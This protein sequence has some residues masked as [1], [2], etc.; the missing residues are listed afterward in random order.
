MPG[1]EVLRQS[2]E[3]GG[4]Q[5]EEYNSEP[6]STGQLIKINSLSLNPTKHK[7]RDLYNKQEKM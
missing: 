5:R 7:L 1:L 2:E 3:I 6:P 4:G